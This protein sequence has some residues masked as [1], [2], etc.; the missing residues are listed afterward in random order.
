MP[1]AHFS[2]AQIRKLNWSDVVTFKTEN[3]AQSY[4]VLVIYEQADE[5][6]Q[7]VMV[8]MEGA[9]NLKEVGMTNLEEVYLRITEHSNG[10]SAALLE[11]EDLTHYVQQFHFYFLLTGASLVSTEHQPVRA[12][13][14]DGEEEWD[15][16]VGDRRIRA[17]KVMKS[18]YGECGE[19][20]AHVFLGWDMSAGDESSEAFLIFLEVLSEDP[21]TYGPLEEE[22]RDHL[23]TALMHA[24]GYDEVGDE[25][26]DPEDELVD[27][28]P[29]DELYS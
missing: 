25:E 1:T 28:A 16:I 9:H 23:H 18:V 29:D 4:T 14:E 21:L 5:P 15:I 10:L 19:S 12:I 20:T 3:G 7:L 11:G 17:R 8:C 6:H 26:A 27:D 2:L 13:G 24:M 22:D